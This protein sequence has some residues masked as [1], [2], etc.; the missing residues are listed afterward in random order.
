MKELYKVISALSFIFVL[1]SFSSCKKI[2]GEGP[3]KTETRGRSG[4]TEINTSIGGSV[5]IRKDSVYKVEVTAQQNILQYLETNVVG[6]KL[7]VKMRDG[8]RINSYQDMV[9]TIFSPEI[10]GVKLSGSGNVRV[11]GLLEPFNF[12]LDVSGSGN[13]NVENVQ[14]NTFGA[15]I[16]GSGN[17]VVESGNVVEENLKISGSGD[18][19]LAAVKAK[20]VF[21]TTSGSGTMKLQAA[22]RLDVS[23]SGS[24]SVYYIGNPIVSSRISGSGRV[25][26]L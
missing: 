4:F 18:I 2:T 11:F 19:N 24:G 20:S 26:P 9:V 15:N 25:V 14:A 12:W 5:F 8:I 7:V 16:S 17:I 1:I 6:N 22:D 13:I 23:I 3:L 21:T 10:S